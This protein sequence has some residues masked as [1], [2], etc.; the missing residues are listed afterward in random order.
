MTLQCP[1]ATFPKRRLLFLYMLQVQFSL[2]LGASL[3]TEVCICN[4][5]EALA[6]VVIYRVSEVPRP[7]N[8]GMARG[9]DVLGPHMPPCARCTIT[10]C[11]CLPPASCG[12]S[13]AYNS[14]LG[15]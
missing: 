10:A 5:E 7:K 9:A 2:S 12:A 4:A 8:C 11:S 3:A 15:C 1:S 13:A 14:L 6:C